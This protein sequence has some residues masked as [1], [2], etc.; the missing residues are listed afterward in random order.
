MNT[1]P[2]TNVSSSP[3]DIEALTPNHFLLGRMFASMP[4]KTNSKPLT[5]MKQWKFAQQLS[6][7]V[8]NRLLKEFIPT[9]LPRQ[10]WTSKTPPIPNGQPVW[11]LEY[12]TP[13]EIWP[14]GRIESPIPS[15]DNVIRQY[16]VRT[17]RGSVQIPAIGLDPNCPDFYTQHSVPKISNETG[18]SSPTPSFWNGKTEEPAALPS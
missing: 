11:I 12:L 9:L 18:A 10:K 7:H 15:A 2:I 8:W 5:V 14:L 3:C 6:D 4:P 16:N 17:H 1:R 13:S